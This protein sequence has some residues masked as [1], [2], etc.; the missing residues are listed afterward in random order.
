MI[1][2]PSKF[3]TICLKKCNEHEVKNLPILEKK[4]T[5]ATPEFKSIQELMAQIN[6]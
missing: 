4:K 3:K 5:K 2:K 1:V 6:G